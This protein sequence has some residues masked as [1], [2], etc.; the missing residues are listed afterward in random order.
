[1]AFILFSETFNIHR[2]EFEA[3]DSLLVRSFLYLAINYF[4]MTRWGMLERGIVERSGFTAEQY[5][6]TFEILYERNA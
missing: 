1:M 3:Q 4:V 5:P 6:L 2:K